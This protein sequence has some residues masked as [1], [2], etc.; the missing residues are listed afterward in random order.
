MTVGIVTIPFRFEGLR[1]IDQALDGVEEIAKHV[2]ALLVIN[3]E[4]LREIYPELTVLN[5]FSKADDTL[6]I[7]AKSIAEIITVYGLINLDFEDVKTV[8]KNGGVAIM[9]MGYGEGEGQVKQAIDSALHSPLLNNKDIFKS[10]RLLLNISFSDKDE[11]EQLTM[12]EVNEIHEF[13]SH[14]QSDVETKFGMATDATLGNKVKITILAS[15]FALD[16]TT[17]KRLHEDERKRVEDE[18]NERVKAALR[19]KFYAN[20]KD[21]KEI[22][23]PRHLYIFNEEDLNDDDIISMIEDI[24]AYKRTKEQL[25]SVKRKSATKDTISDASKG[26]TEENDPP[27]VLFNGII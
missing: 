8:M 14:F 21:Q 19:S 18:E 4:R 9:S 10:K 1:K 27:M 25:E 24:P 13:M 15:G 12:E 6:C 20:D 2:D 3:N 16:T 7:A 26:V 5:A 11:K 22:K 17:D 23:R